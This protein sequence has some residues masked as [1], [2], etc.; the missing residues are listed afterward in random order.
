MPQSISLA[1]AR[2]THWDWRFLINGYVDELLYERGTLDTTLPFSPSNKTPSEN[3]E[4]DAYL[5]GIYAAEM[6]ACEASPAGQQ[7]PNGKAERP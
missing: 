2:N 4:L 7:S 3:V 5:A 6:K 1:Y